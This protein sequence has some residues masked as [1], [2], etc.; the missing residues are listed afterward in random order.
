[1]LAKPS[2]HQRYSFE[3]R[4][5]KAHFVGSQI[6]LAITEDEIKVFLP[7]YSCGAKYSLWGS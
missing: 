6:F 7:L 1:M 3:V 5:L 4:C 2:I